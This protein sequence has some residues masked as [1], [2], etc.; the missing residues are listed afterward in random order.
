MSNEARSVAAVSAASPAAFG[1]RPP[2]SGER[3]TSGQPK[4]PTAPDYRLVIEQGS[5]PGQF[6][7]KTIDRATGE[8]IR[9][10]PREDLIK[11]AD[12]PAYV[13]GQV[14]FTQA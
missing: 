5:R 4:A 10:L 8:T 6:V 9:Q 13:A 14:A 7:Y 3:E 12:D 11:L 1:E 2:N